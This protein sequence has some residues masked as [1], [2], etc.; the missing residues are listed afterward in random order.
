MNYVPLVPFE[1]LRAPVSVGQDYHFECTQ[2][3]KC[4][5]DG[6]QMT[7]QEAFLLRD[8]FPIR[9]FISV[10]SAAPT[11]KEGM[12]H[13]NF[14]QKMGSLQ[15]KEGLEKKMMYVS[16]ATYQ[17]QNGR[18]IALADN[19]GCSVYDKRPSICK[20]VPMVTFVPDN[21]MHTRLDSFGAKYGCLS[22][23][24]G[25]SISVEG[26]NTNREAIY[27]DVDYSSMAAMIMAD[28]VG[29]QQGRRS[30]GP[31]H[32]AILFEALAEQRNENDDKAEL[33]AS[34]QLALLEQLVEEAIKRKNK[35]D[36]P[37]TR[38][39]REMIGEL[40]DYIRQRKDKMQHD[41]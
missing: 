2:C 14:M 9:L 19:G 35:A 11:D 1:Q 21:Q 31:V 40:Q 18:C 7:F 6:P 23:K 26:L 32:I 33:F 20:S 17:Y 41:Q 13:L 4:C 10:S 34:S 28:M 24:E 15:I 12:E 3:G 37:V 16:P 39:Y 8:V 30:V 25:A 22:K 29:T 27:N 5:S 38:M 36:M